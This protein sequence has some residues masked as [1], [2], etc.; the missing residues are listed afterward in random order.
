MPPFADVVQ[1]LSC[2]LVFVFQK[3]VVYDSNDSSFFPEN[4]GL[5]AAL[6]PNKNK[7]TNKNKQKP[8]ANAP[9]RAS[10]P[11]NS[12]LTRGR[13]NV[14]SDANRDRAKSQPSPKKPSNASTGNRS[15]T[16]GRK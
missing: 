1:L 11:N 13:T 4:I 7:E 10:T 3:E 14:R 15:S 6:Q 2:F 12:Q 16:P 9:A 5:E 8:G